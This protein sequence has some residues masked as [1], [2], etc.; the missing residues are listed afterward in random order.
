MR[1]AFSPYSTGGGIYSTDDNEV[2]QALD[3]HQFNGR[4]YR[5]LEEQKKKPS[6]SK[7]FQALHDA[8]MLVIILPNRAI[9]VISRASRTS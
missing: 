9:K 6:N 8:Q 4:K 3:A 2:I 5:K 1:I 7:R